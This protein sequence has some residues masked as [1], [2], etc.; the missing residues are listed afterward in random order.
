[1]PAYRI[2]VEFAITS[3]V[4]VEA[5]SRE[6]AVIVAHYAPLPDCADWE[7]VDDT[8][9][10]REPDEYDLPN[11]DAIDDMGRDATPR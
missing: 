6:E 8:F 2:P 4:T 9:A 5:V 11:L 10:V 7:Y 1:M 3:T